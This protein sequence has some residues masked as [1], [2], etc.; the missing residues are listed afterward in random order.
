VRGSGDTDAMVTEIRKRTSGAAS[1]QLIFSG[2]AT[3]D[4]NPFW[5]PT[6][7]EE[8]ED[9]AEKADRA[10]VAKVMWMG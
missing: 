9:L 5:V 3:L 1:P 10:N 8:L 7:G 4:L 6:T 2:F